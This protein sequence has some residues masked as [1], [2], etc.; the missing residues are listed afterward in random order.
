[1]RVDASGLRAFRRWRDEIIIAQLVML[2]RVGNA[3]LRCI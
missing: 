3:T 2:P 1:M